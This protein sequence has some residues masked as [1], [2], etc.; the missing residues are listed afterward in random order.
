MKYKIEERWFGTE[1]EPVWLFQT[2][3]DRPVQTFDLTGKKSVKT[4]RSKFLILPA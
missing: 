1:L 2:G 4:G 3:P